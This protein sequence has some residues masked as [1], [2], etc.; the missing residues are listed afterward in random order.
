MAS[1]DGM[2]HGVHGVR[3]TGPETHQWNLAL[4]SDGYQQGAELAT[5][6]QDADDFAAKMLQI[7]PFT[8]LVGEINIFRIDVSSTDSLA[9][10]PPPGTTPKTYFDAAFSTDPN[11]ARLLTINVATAQD[12]LQTH[13]PS[14]DRGLVIVNTTGTGGS[15]G[16]VA[17]VV[18]GKS[19]HR[20][21]LH[22]LG[23]TAFGL[24]DEYEYLRGCNL[25]PPE[26]R[27]VP[28]SE[29]FANANITIRK[30]AGEI[31]WGTMLTDPL[32]ALPTTT[33]AN[34]TDC[35]PQN[36]AHLGAVVG[37]FDGAGTYHCGVYRPQVNC[38]MRNYNRDFCDVCV[39]KIKATIL[40]AQVP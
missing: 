20:I 31:P 32:A 35:D 34:C 1:T 29:E 40:S 23:H 30:S 38:C 21:A 33:N 8:G 27:G 25:V 26:N 3:I 13:L 16:G 14:A 36:H 10:D 24:G 18:R 19:G 4:L 39:A 9:H 17:A 7:P 15:G 11:L 12:V 28:P 37:A 5:F 6:A 2:V 22:E